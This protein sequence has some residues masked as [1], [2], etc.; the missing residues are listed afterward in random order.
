MLL[1]EFCE[2]LYELRVSQTVRESTWVFPTL[3]AIHIYSMAIFV[4]VMA[5]VDLRLLGFRIEQQPRQ[6]LSH[7]TRRVLR[8]GW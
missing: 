5:A 3:D 1:L 7:F 2:W 6:P 8:W 4:M